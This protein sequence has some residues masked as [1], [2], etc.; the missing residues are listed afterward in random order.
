[1]EKVVLLALVVIANHASLMDA[2]PQQQFL[3]DKDATS[4][5]LTTAPAFSN[6]IDGSTNTTNEDFMKIPWFMVKVKPT[7]NGSIPDVYVNFPNGDRDRIKIIDDVQ[8]GKARGQVSTLESDAELETYDDNVVRQGGSQLPPESDYDYAYDDYNDD[9]GGGLDIGL[10]SGFGDYEEEYVEAESNT[11]RICTHSGVLE[12][13]PDSYFVLW[14][15]LEDPESQMEIHAFT[16]SRVPSY[17]LYMVDYDGTVKSQHSMKIPWFMIKKRPTLN[18]SVPDIYVNFPNGDRDRLMIIDDNTVDYSKGPEEVIRS[19]STK[20]KTPEFGD[21]IVRLG[22]SLAADK[23][24][25]QV[26]HGENSERR[27]KRSDVSDYDYASEVETACNHSGVLEK[28]PNDTYFVLWGCLDNPRSQMEI[29]AFTPKR[30][31]AYGFYIV[32]YDGAVR[33][34]TL[35]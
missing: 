17:G 30:V 20:E 12:R 7:S 16:P 14:G 23:D 27:G 18:G 4:G 31:P 11:A 13:E 3:D 34:G 19:A 6:T 2:R 15:C 35:K 32:D 29:H 33:E 5:P 22:G 1:M 8:E 21:R 24:E 10:R 26:N 25:D 28:D 9:G